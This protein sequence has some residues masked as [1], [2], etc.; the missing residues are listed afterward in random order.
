M[1]EPL[2]LKFNTAQIPMMFSGVSGIDNPYKLK[3]FLEDNVQQRLQRLDGVAQVLVYGGTDREIQVAVDPTRLKGKGL[4]V[5]GI[6]TAL[7]AQNMN[8][9]AGYMVNGGTDY[10]VRAMGEFANIDDIRNSIVGA[11][12]DGTPVRLYEVADVKD[13][14]KEK[15]SLSRMN[16]R[17]TVFLI[18]SKQSGANTLKVSKAV[19]KE[20]EAIK[21]ANPQLIFHTIFDQGEPVERVTGRTIR[22]GVIG[23]FLA[24]ILL[25]I[26]LGNLRPTLII[27][28]AIPLS[29]ITTFIALYVGGIHAQPDDAGRFRARQ[30]ED[31]LRL[32][33]KIRSRIIARKR[34]DHAFTNGSSRNTLH[35][36]ALV[37]NGMKDELR[38]RLL[39]ASISLFTAL[40]TLSVFA[41]L[42]FEMMRITGGRSCATGSVFP[43]R[44]PLHRQLRRA[45]PACLGRRA[46]D[47]VADVVDVGELA[48]ARTRQSVPPFTM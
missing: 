22:E 5:D 36:F 26:F 45:A 24:I 11:A 12:A 15:R 34:A 48:I 42:C 32:P 20:I 37:E 27:A 17:P 16:G 23:A 25:L 47:R 44:C 4:S 35:R 18:I 3:K 33:R 29:I 10:L 2:V 6:A 41:P 9:P 40:D 30:Y 7:G 39:I 1:S 38:I 28:V 46:D 8:T 21:K 14:Y 13:T 43:C 31:G 19:N